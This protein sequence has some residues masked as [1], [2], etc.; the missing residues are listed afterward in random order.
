VIERA[1]ARECCRDS[2]GGVVVRESQRP[3]AIRAISTRVRAWR[4]SPESCYRCGQAATALIVQMPVCGTCRATFTRAR[5]RTALGTTSA[6]VATR[7]DT[8]GDG[9]FIGGYPIVFN[10]RS[11]DLGGF[12]EIIRPPA[13]DHM[14]TSGDD[15]RAL[16]DHDSSKIIGRKSAGTLTFKAD[17]V[18]LR[19]RVDPPRASY[20]R[21]IIDALQRRDVTGGSFGFNVLDDEWYEEDHGQVMRDVWSMRVSEV[22]IV[23]FPAYED[24]DMR[25]GDNIPPLRSVE[26]LRRLHRQRMAG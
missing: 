25:A 17:S 9:I 19:I 21:D 11:V 6:R 8:D 10:R 16:V 14:I 13:I 15:V 5:D 1:I 7:A 4:Q 23:S 2:H 12:R 22:S 20:A 26:F 24:T 18:G 3:D